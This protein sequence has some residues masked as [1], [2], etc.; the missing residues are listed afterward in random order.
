MDRVLESH[1]WDLV[2]ASFSVQSESQHESLVEMLEN[3]GAESSEGAGWN[4]PKSLP[5]L[6]EISESQAALMTLKIQTVQVKD[7][8]TDGV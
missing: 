4:P 5:L 6:H 2:V 3:L 1:R 7:K 8:D